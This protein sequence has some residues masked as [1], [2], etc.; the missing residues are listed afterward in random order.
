MV[1]SIHSIVGDTGMLTNTKKD[2]TLKK[3][4]QRY[5]QRTV[6]FVKNLIAFEE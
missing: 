3:A 2:F 5:V 1:Q 4:K 6:G